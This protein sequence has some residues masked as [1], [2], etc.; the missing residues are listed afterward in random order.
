MGDK[1]V[2]SVL[3]TL[4]RLNWDALVFPLSVGSSQISLFTVI[5]LV[6]W[7]CPPPSCQKRLYRNVLQHR[8]QF[9][10]QLRPKQEEISKCI[11]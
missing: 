7:V 5:G 6:L 11:H 10:C 8:P 1:N 9:R 2:D 3:G 4:E